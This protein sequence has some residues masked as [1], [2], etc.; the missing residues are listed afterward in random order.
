[1]SD[2]SAHATAR[3]AGGRAPAGEALP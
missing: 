3:P 2:Q 1:L